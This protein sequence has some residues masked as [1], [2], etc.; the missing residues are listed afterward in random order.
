MPKKDYSTH[1]IRP[2]K[3]PTLGEASRKTTK[4][5]RMAARK[6]MGRGRR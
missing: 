4:G 5:Q 2:P 3:K 6:A 1:M